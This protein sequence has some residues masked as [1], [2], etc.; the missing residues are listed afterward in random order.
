MPFDIDEKFFFHLVC[1][2]NLFIHLFFINESIY[3][4][5]IITRGQSSE[6]TKYES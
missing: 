6:V 2:I 1:N 5:L 4:E 3:Q